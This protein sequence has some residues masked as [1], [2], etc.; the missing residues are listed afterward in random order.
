MTSGHFGFAAGVKSVAP[1]VPLWALM[2]GT[3][4]LDIGFIV[5]VA[6]GLES[7]SPL[8][9][10][11]PA[12]GE[13]VI[14]AYYSHSLAGALLIAA[15]SGWLAVWKWGERAGFV[16]GAVVFSHWILDLIVHRP[17]LPIL[18]GNLGGL[19]LLGFGLWRLPAVSAG[20]E[21]ALAL[22]GAYL[23][24][25]IALTASAPVGDKGARRIRPLVAAGVTGLLIVLLLIVDVFQLPMWIAIVLL[26]LLIVLCGRLDSRLDWSPP[27]T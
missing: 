10:A 23:Y 9:P 12:Y 17:D 24:Y 16:I 1:K 6:A 19:P 27:A 25:R 3:Y 13:I 15:V 11:H 14:R 2:L 21:L 26:L 18:P 22:G 5:L 4:L 20:V 8:D 7:F